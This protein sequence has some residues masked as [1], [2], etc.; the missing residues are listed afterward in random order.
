MKKPEYNPKLDVTCASN[1]SVSYMFLRGNKV[2][3]AVHPYGIESLVPRKDGDGRV[4]NTL[5]DARK[6]AYNKGY[7][8][9]VIDETRKGRNNAHDL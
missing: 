1:F 2:R 7:I 4:F 8:V 6:F 5:E 9:A 3:L